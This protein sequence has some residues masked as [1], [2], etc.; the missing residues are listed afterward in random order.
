[1]KQFFMGIWAFAFAQTMRF[2][3]DPVALFFTFL[4]PLLFLFVF[5]SL[6]KNN[7]DIN[8]QVALI[9]RSETK[10]SQEFVKQATEGKNAI[11]KVDKKVTSI[12]K[13]KELMGRGQLDSIV[14][15]P[16]NFG[17][18]NKQG[19]PSGQVNVYYEKSNPQTGQ[20][21]TSIMQTSLDKLNFEL[22]KHDD[23]FTVQQKA[24]TTANLSQFDYTFSGLIGFSLLSMGIFGLASGL[25]SDKKA[26]MLRRLRATPFSAA[27]LIVG[28]LLNYLVVGVLSIT[29]MF[30]VGLLVFGFD[31]RGDYLSFAAVVLLGMI[32]MLGIGLAIGGWAKNEM[33]A[34]P[35]ANIV[36]FPMM[37]LTGTFFPRFIMPEWLQQ[38][39]T[40]LPLTPIVDSIRYVTTEGKTV[41][42]LGPELAL[43]GIWILIIYAIAIRV[44]RWE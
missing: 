18:P 8:F 28:T 11:L 24:T 6:F 1:M 41:F 23:P 27:Q 35:L 21:L 4:F 36:A 25:P 26:G 33:Q 38:I 29:V 2:F 13:A 14:E 37:F 15:L 43:I 31:M 7:D 20:T 12:D 44:F 40:F 32:T 17:K 10:F 34:S 30:T 3:R 9:N 42:E 5:G 16:E 22:T 19:V 39:T